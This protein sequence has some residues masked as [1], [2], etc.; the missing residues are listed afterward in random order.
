MYISNEFV[1][2]EG[3]KVLFPNVSQSRIDDL[4]NVN[5]FGTPT[6]F[7]GCDV[8][9]RAE[10]VR[11]GEIVFSEDRPQKKASDSEPEQPDYS[12]EDQKQLKLNADIINR[13]GN[14][15]AQD[16]QYLVLCARKRNAAIE[17]KYAAKPT[18]DKSAIQKQIA[19]LEEK[20]QQLLAKTQEYHKMHTPVPD[21]DL[22]EYQRC[23]RRINELQSQL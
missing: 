21:R 9:D 18:V 20:K 10:A 7:A 16:K 2:R 8:V 17:K 15:Q 19:E 4:W 13:Y 14:H 22:A 23:K 12:P 5:I 11:A 3:L 1:D 6:Q